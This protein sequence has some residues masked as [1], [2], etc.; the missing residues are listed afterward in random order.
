MLR[1]SLMSEWLNRRHRKALSSEDLKVQTVTWLNLLRLLARSPLHHGT[2]HIL[3]TVFFHP[4]FPNRPL[5]LCSQHSGGLL[6]QD[7]RDLTVV[8]VIKGCALVI[9]A[10]PDDNWSNEPVALVIKDGRYLELDLLSLTGLPKLFPGGSSAVVFSKVAGEEMKSGVYVHEVRRGVDVEKDEVRCEGQGAACNE[11]RLKSYSWGLL[12]ALESQMQAK[13]IHFQAVFKLTKAE[14][15]YVAYILKCLVQTTGIRKQNNS[16]LCPRSNPQPLSALM[17]TTSLWKVHKTMKLHTSL[18]SF[19]V[20]PQQEVI[21]H[22]SA[23]PSVASLVILPCKAEPIQQKRTKKPKGVLQKRT[24]LPLL[25][26]DREMEP[27]IMELQG[28]PCP[29]RHTRLDLSLT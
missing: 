7:V 8:D 27:K 21:I 4:I 6:L 23:L 2:F 13:L 9:G 22:P 14:M 12:K 1:F 25:K 24:V 10:Q 11:E 5:E 15:P 16:Q 28:K 18:R 19:V 3:E 26:R 20:N 29:W 17:T